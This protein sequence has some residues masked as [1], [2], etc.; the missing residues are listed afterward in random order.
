MAI[1]NR[2]NLTS[3]SGS[4]IAVDTHTKTINFCSAAN[5]GSSI[6]TSSLPYESNSFDEEFFQELTELV[7]QQIK[8][9][10]EMDMQ[11][12]SLVIPDQLFLIDTVSIPV[13]HRKAMQ[14][15]LSFAMVNPMMHIG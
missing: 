9:N 12:V 3:V 4:V 14:Q 6:A 15:S 7:K 8:N 1:I 2:G 5:N 11:R 10:P 13:I